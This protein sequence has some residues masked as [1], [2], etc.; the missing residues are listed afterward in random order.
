MRVIHP[1][2]FA[3]SH[4]AGKNAKNCN[5]VIHRSCPKENNFSDLFAP[6]FEHAGSYHDKELLQLGTSRALVRISPISELPFH[7]FF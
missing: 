7:E 2:G 5:T 3:A 1:C 6:Q 4:A